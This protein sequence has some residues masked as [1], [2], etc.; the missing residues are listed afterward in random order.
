MNATLRKKNKEGSI[1]EEISIYTPYYVLDTLVSVVA[2]IVNFYAYFSL[3]KT[4]GFKNE[5]FI[6]Y[7]SKAFLF[8]GMSTLFGLF[9]FVTRILLVGMVGGS[10][11][12]DLYVDV[13]YNLAFVVGTF[14]LILGIKNL[15]LLRAT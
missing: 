6:S 2:V 5:M 14:Y 7:F 10:P 1:L 12:F 11:Y 15:K 13:P 4:F 3:K 8:F 9:S